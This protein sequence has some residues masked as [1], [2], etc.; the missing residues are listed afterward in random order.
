MA[1]RNYCITVSGSTNEEKWVEVRTVI[2]PV[3]RNNQASIDLMNADIAEYNKAILD[4]GISVA[5]DK[6]LIWRLT[7]GTSLYGNLP[8]NQKINSKLGRRYL[9]CPYDTA[10][11]EARTRA[12]LLLSD[13]DV[14]PSRFLHE[15]G[16]DHYYMKVSPRG[17]RWGY[18]CTFPG[19]PF[20]I[21]NNKNYFYI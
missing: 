6:W 9:Q 11:S 5:F 14:L 8:T 12:L 10:C 3:P 15:I 19:C 2:G 4:Y 16:T 18:E 7:V 13:T 17:N 1:I 21:T 20:H